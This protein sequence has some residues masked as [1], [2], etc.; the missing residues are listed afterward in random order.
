MK[1]PQ[2]MESKSENP[3]ALGLDP[4]IMRGPPSSQRG[5][6]EFICTSHIWW[7][8]RCYGDVCAH[9]ATRGLFAGTGLRQVADRSV[10]MMAEFRLGPQ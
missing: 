1:S 9:T 7:R 4:T 6:D 8:C 2:R 5:D 3:A 10:G